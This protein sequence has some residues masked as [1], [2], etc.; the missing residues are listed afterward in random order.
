VK[1]WP[2]RVKILD[3][4][5]GIAF[6]GWFLYQRKYWNYTGIDI[7]KEHIAAAEELFEYYNIPGKVLQADAHQ[8]P[9]ADRSFDIC[10]FIGA[11]IYE[12]VDVPVAI[13]EITRILRTGGMIIVDIPLQKHSTYDQIFTIEQVHDMLSPY[14]DI[15]LIPYKGHRELFRAY[16]R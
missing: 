3:V 4:A 14:E 5:C 15:T 9:I 6:L 13:S 12:D 11:T 16:R 1:K 2:F 10:T 7:G 8:L